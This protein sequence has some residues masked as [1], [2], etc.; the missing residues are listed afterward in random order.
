MGI[1][2]LIIGLI[3]GAIYNAVSDNGFNKKSGRTLIIGFLIVGSVL[4]AI[5]GHAV[6]IL[7][8]F[9]LFAGWVFS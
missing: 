5:F 4:E 1:A 8:L 9:I 2:F 6:G 3:A 7:F